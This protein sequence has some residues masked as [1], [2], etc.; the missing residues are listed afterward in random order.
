MPNNVIVG[1]SPND[2]FYA[3]AISQGVMP[4][5]DDCVAL[6]PYD[7]TWDVSCG[8]WFS[9]NSG[10]CIKKELCINQDKANVLT[11][12]QG[13]HSSADEKYMNEKMN[14]DN[15][16]LNTINLG[17]GIVFLLFVIYKNQK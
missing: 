10:N 13:K 9:D 1:Y 3:D 15:V 5:D 7:Q 12:I 16:L 4:T 11:D 17:I 14:Y 6:K 8:S 2:F